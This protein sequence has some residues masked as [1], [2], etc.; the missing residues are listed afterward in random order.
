MFE[1]ALS[2]AYDQTS[3][4]IERK[5]KLVVLRNILIACAAAGWCALYLLNSSADMSLLWWF[6][7]LGVL[8]G[9]FIEPRYGVYALIFFGLVGDIVVSG[10]LPFDKNFSSAESFFYMGERYKFSPIEF[11][12]LIT[13]I[14]WVARTA[15]RNEF[16]K[17]KVRGTMVPALIFTSIAAFM[18][19]Y[20]VGTGST[21]RIALWE[22]R[23]IF[24]IFMMLVLVTHTVKTRA[25][26]LTI[27]WL[28]AAALLIE[29]LLALNHAAAIGQVGQDLTEHSASIH[30]NMLFLLFIIAW[31]IP[32]G[33]WHF[34][35]LIPFLI[36]TVGYTYILSDRRSA[37]LGLFICIALAGVYFWQERRLLF[38]F[39]APTLLVL[40][41]GYL[42][43]FWNSNSSLGKPAQS[44]KSAIAPA[45]SLSQADKQSNLYREIENYNIIFTIQQ[46]PITGVGFGNPFYMPIPLP[47]ISFFEFWEY[48]THNSIMWYWMKTGVFGFMS[49]LFMVSTSISLGARTAWQMANSDIRTVTIV[50]TLFLITHFIYAYVDISWTTQSML[51]VGLAMGVINIVADF[52]KKPEFEQLEPA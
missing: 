18:L 14:S 37:M 44:I 21:V 50:L 43:A 19:V 52:P 51:L 27:I 15:I 45:D 10:Y 17:I 39:V 24:Y 42:G 22:S 25:H 26:I 20:H 28:A 33:G 30:Y 5:N 32:K 13:T 1:T 29:S 48:I 41:I 11:L 46:K 34:R 3:K 9:L 16:Y 23:A 4:Q 40:G 6:S 8:V 47:D 36:P 38:Y 49:M 31:L 2:H 7:F 12:L 35:L